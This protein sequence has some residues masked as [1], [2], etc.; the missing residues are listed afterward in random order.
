MF[1]RIQSTGESLDGVAPGDAIELL[2]IGT[3]IERGGRFSYAL[4]PWSAKSGTPKSDVGL[5]VQVTPVA[6][7]PVQ[8]PADDAVPLVYE[9][10]GIPSCWALPA[11]STGW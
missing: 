5:M 7:K 8:H 1:L 9:G 11:G 10:P 3:A 6:V 4:P 2:H